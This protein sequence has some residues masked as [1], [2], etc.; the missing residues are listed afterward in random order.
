MGQGD[1]TVKYPNRGDRNIVLIEA[2]MI[3][4][5]RYQGSQVS[6]WRARAGSACSR[7]AS[8]GRGRRRKSA[9]R[10]SYAWLLPGAVAGDTEGVGGGCAAARQTIS[11]G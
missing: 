6:R 11:K 10:L 3:G 2:P 9:V 4:W 7:G 5:E 1:P 8:S